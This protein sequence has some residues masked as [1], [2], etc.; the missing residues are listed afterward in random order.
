M[1]F[2]NNNKEDAKPKSHSQDFIPSFIRKTYDILE[3]ARF[4]QYI[5]WSPEGTAL[6]IKK[7]SEFSQKVLPI[8]FKH[9]NFTSFVRQLNMYDFHKKR[10]QGL[11]H[12]YIHDLF[13]KG[14]RNLLQGIKRK[15][16]EHT[17]EKISKAPE[18]QQISNAVPE[19]LSSLFKE[20]QLI[21]HLY[22]E[23]MNRLAA[24]ERRAK[25]LAVQNQTLVSQIYCQNNDNER[26]FKPN[27]VRGES[28][29]ELT[30]DQLPM[31]LGKMTLN[32]AAGCRP[33]AQVT[34][35]FTQAN[36]AVYMKP[37]F[38]TVG[39]ARGDLYREESTVSGA[40]TEV[41]RGS[42][43]VQSGIDNEEVFEIYQSVPQRV[44]VFEQFSSFPKGF[45]TQ[46]PRMTSE[47]SINR[48]EMSAGQMIDSWNLD[49]GNDEMICFADQ[50][51]DRPMQPMYQDRS[52]LGKR[53][54]E[55]SMNMS[56]YVAE[57]PMK[58][59]ELCISNRMGLISAGTEDLDSNLYA[60]NVMPAV[61]GYD[62]QM[63][64]DSIE[65]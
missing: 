15:T 41:S 56:L 63:G 21:K 58:R 59:P 43:A 34:R 26:A 50:K 16:H 33:Q 2:N 39:N 1:A 31:T 57:P 3:E 45:N 20:N 55:P 35:L 18:V 12:V 7:P 30:Q 49:L 51:A 28:Q 14:K 9:N 11:D 64:I 40:S 29:A 23:A 37:S 22:N 4:P 42:P 61:G 48:Q 32:M 5:D 25:E 52:L 44:E 38:N 8:Y 62:Q 60:N 54:F 10:T 53:Q 19:D 47:L 13:Q 46:A 24:L 27:I 17:G 6:V 36:P 65:F